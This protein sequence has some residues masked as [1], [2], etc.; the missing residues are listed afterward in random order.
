MVQGE[1]D[2]IRRLEHEEMQRKAR[3]VDLEKARDAAVAGI[4]ANGGTVPNDISEYDLIVVS[5]LVNNSR[6]INVGDQT[7]NDSNPNPAAIPL[8]GPITTSTPVG[9]LLPAGSTPSDHESFLQ[10][11]AIHLQ[12]QQLV[13]QQSGVSSFSGMPTYGGSALNNSRQR[14]LLI[15]HQLQRQAE[16]DAMKPVGDVD[17]NM[18][19]GEVEDE[20]GG[21]EEQDDGQVRFRVLPFHSLISIVLTICTSLFLACTS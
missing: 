4:V 12:Q 16:A 8:S 6:N 5:W 20:E 15:K 1:V 2:I 11:Q 17:V 10:Q 14:S 21:D 7:I 18:E 3:I 13:M 19:A 9:S